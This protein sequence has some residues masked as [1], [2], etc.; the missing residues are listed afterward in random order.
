MLLHHIAAVALYPGFIFGGLM[1]GG[2]IVAW[3]HDIADI[4]A[5]SLRLSHNLGFKVSTTILFITNAT[6]W[7]YTRLMLLPYFIV[8]SILYY[9]FPE[10]LSHF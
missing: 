10:S 6:V 2:V 3:L 7:F 5:T 4:F 1:G 8:L 9:K